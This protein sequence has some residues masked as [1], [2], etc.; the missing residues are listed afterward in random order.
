MT[1]LRIKF[2]DDQLGRKF[3]KV[4]VK[5]GDQVTQAARLAAID[6][7]TE[8]L[9][10]GRA[11]IRSAGNFG[12]RWTR[13]LTAP[14]TEGGGRI[15]I[16]VRHAVPYFMVFQRG[17]VIHGKPLLWIPLSFAP[18][19]QGVRARD[20]PGKLFRVNRVGKA[21]LLLG[22]NPA[23]PKYFGKR[24]VRIPKKFHV[25]EIGREVSRRMKDFYKVRMAQIM[26]GK[27]RN[28]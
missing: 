1:T 9:S 2:S 11:D 27:G 25:L 26:K 16:N 19:A 14:I 24:F 15:V 5:R 17:K 23:K 18:E 4:M 21:P 22:G 12:T 8:I 3:K 7:Q 6:V 13:G 20:Y 28:G 10:R